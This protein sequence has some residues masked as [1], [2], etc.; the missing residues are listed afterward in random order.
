MVSEHYSLGSLVQADRLQGCCG[1]DAV[2]IGQ[3]CC[4]WL[5]FVVTAAAACALRLY[6]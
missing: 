1:A 4:L 6:T 2:D 5:M 3:E